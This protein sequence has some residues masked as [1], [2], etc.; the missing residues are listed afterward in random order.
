MTENIKLAIFGPVSAGKTT[1]NNALMSNKCSGMARKKLTMLPQIYQIVNDNSHIDTIEEIYQKN[2]SS[3]EEILKLREDGEFDQD[4]HFTELIHN[5]HPIPDF[6]QLPDNMATYSI[7]DMP[8]LNCAGDTLYYDYVKKISATIDIYLIV[9]DINSGLNT[10]DEINIL[11]FLVDQIQQNNHGYIHILINKCDNITIN[12][13]NITLAD[14]E[15]D[16]LYKRIIEAINKYCAPIH[17]KVSISPLCSQKLY[18]YR[19][20]KNDITTIEEA[21]L[22]DII[23]D[24]LGKK[25]LKD[26]P[27]ITAKRE[28]VSELMDLSFNDWIKNTGYNQFIYCLDQILKNYSEIVFNHINADLVKLQDISVD[29][30]DNYFDIMEDKIDKINARIQR[31]KQYTELPIA[32]LQLNLLDNLDIIN[33]KLN[34]HLI[35]SYSDSPIN[36]IETIIRKI[37]DYHIMLTNLYKSNLLRAAK[38]ELSNSREQLLIKEFEEEFNNEIFTELFDDDGTGYT[39]VDDASSDIMIQ[40][41]NIIYELYKKSIHNTLSK[42]MNKAICIFDFLSSFNFP[43]LLY[44]HNRSD[45]YYKKLLIMA[46]VDLL[47]TKK[48]KEDIF[49]EFLPKLITNRDA[50]DDNDILVLASK[51]ITNFMITQYKYGEEAIY[52]KIICTYWTKLNSSK[53]EQSGREIQYI[54]LISRTFNTYNS[55]DSIFEKVDY[56]VYNS[57]MDTLDSIFEVLKCYC[58]D[59]TAIND[60]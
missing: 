43:E 11:K 18:I 29:S 22:N 36:I 4:C 41:T 55:V 46:F 9:F 26:F 17:D 53:I 50:H 59:I 10:T 48:M 20:V 45:F 5:I 34:E 31:A 44:N 21:H 2:K 33:A 12:G 8:G 42:D 14:E 49:L 47:A 39:Q 32:Q 40:D 13:D 15:L 37:D 24:E 27:H 28:Y 7:L 16:E 56:D 3:N 51:A 60:I 57:I 38:V 6:I 23:L 25:G 58:I 54:Y 19:S 52:V 30:N 35:A 1:F